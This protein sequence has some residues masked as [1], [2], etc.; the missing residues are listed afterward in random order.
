MKGRSWLHKSNA[1]STFPWFRVGWDLKHHLVWAF[2][3]TIG[4]LSEVRWLLKGL[5]PW[6][7]FLMAS[8]NRECRPP[9]WTGSSWKNR[10]TV[11]TNQDAGH[12]HL[13]CILYVKEKA[14]CSD[15]S[16]S[17]EETDSAKK[18][19]LTHPS[20]WMQPFFLGTREGPS[21]RCSERIRKCFY[22]RAMQKPFP[23]PTGRAF[24]I[25]I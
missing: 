16:E 10:W 4:K 13:R 20:E 9:L 15:R 23:K 2:H 22:T 21:N 14:L 11:G 5:V 1:H 6:L 18:V 24:I 12:S 7:L 17:L 3:F 25:D 19:T 8:Y